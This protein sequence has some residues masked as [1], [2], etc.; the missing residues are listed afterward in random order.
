MPLVAGAAA[1]VWP[2]VDGVR[3]LGARDE[4]WREISGEL[5]PR[6]V[7]HGHYSNEIANAEYPSAV[8]EAR[9]YSAEQ[10]SLIPGIEGL[11]VASRQGVSVKPGY[12]KIYHAA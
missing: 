1:D 7:L 4:A 5:F 3:H 2:W 11:G 8:D 9:G 6:G 10:I 12:E